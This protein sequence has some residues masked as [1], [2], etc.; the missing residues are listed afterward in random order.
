[1]QKP[2]E[3]II[4]LPYR[5]WP[6]FG[7]CWEIFWKDGYFWLLDDG[8]RHLMHIEEVVSVVV[9][10]AISIVVA[11]LQ[12]FVSQETREQIDSISFRRRFEGIF[13]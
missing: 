6:F 8:S 4:I 1:M 7:A 5:Q 9:A 12:I 13:A 10:A 2:F 3:Q 11:C